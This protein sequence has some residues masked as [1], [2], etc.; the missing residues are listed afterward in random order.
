MKRKIMILFLAAIMMLTACQKNSTETGSSK[1]NLASASSAASENQEKMEE[2][3]EQEPSVTGEAEESRAEE[4]VEE[5]T[6]ET[7]TGEPKKI[8]VGISNRELGSCYD[9]EEYNYVWCPTLC[10]LDE[11][12]EELRKGLSRVNQERWDILHD[13]CVE[14]ADYVRE[15]IDE[16]LIDRGEVSSSVTV[17]RADE[18]IVSFLDETYTYLGGTHPNTYITGFNLD[19]SADRIL[20]LRDVVQDYDGFYD[21]VVSK[22]P[23]IYQSEELNEG[24]EET[25]QD[26]FYPKDQETEK[27][28]WTCDREG[29]T[30]YF[31][32]YVLSCYAAS[33]GKVFVPFDEERSLFRPEFLCD[34]SHFARRLD[35]NASCTED[36]NGDGIG[37]Q[38]SFLAEEQYEEYTTRLSV[39]IGEKTFTETYSGYYSESYLVKNTDGHYYFYVEFSGDNDYRYLEIFD[40]GGEIPVSLGSTPEGESFYGYLMADSEEFILCQRVYMLGT[41][42]GYRTYHVGADGIPVPETEVLTLLIDPEDKERSIKSVRD[43]KVWMVMD[44]NREEEAV[45][46]AGTVFYPRS[47]DG[48]SY[49]ET[50][51]EDGRYCRIRV[52]IEDGMIV[53][54]GIDDDEYFEFLPYAG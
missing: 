5:E 49:L 47:T 16:G 12:H 26:L 28:P 23:E 41:Y 54:D 24:Y 48:S 35:R 8:A 31:N 19:G 7:L 40:L 51:L 43:L 17:E 36:L 50:E 1:G 39:T 34:T 4:S 3:E 10:V 18:R 38:F 37:E 45:L 21:Y 20:T 14:N 13:I 53:I 30:V 29:I 15:L 33:S 52:E 46:P 9:G 11:G 6:E 22:I 32:T 2:Q 27:I 42:T 44:E 25:L